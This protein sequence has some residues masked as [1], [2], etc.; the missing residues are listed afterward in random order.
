MSLWF[1]VAWYAAQTSASGRICDIERLEIVIKLLYMCVS[2]C[3][4][5]LVLS[6]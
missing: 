6:T 3:V 4:L 1:L 2:L 5:V